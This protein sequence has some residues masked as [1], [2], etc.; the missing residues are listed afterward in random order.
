MKFLYSKI[1]F[2]FAIATCFGQQL[3]QIPDINFVHLTDLHV[4]VGNDNDFLLQKIIKEI[5]DSKNEF[6]VITGDLTNRGDDDELNRVHT[7]L[8]DLKIPYYVI[9]GNHET[10][11][12]ESAGLTYKKLWGEDRFV[13]SKGDY[14]FVGFPCGPYMKM[15]DGFVKK[16]DILLLDKTIEESLENSNKKVLSFSHYPL[17]NSLSNYKEVLSVLKKYPVVANF[18]GHGHTL[19]KYNFSGLSGLMG[20]SIISRDGKTR[21]YNE[22]VIN[23][24]SIS[25]YHKK[26][27]EKAV[28]THSVSTKPSTIVIEKESEL[29]QIKAFAN[30]IASIYSVPSFDKRNIYFANSLGTIQSVNLKNKKV[31]W[32]IETRNSIYFQPIIVKNNLIVGDIEGNIMAFDKQSSKQKWIRAVE[33]ILV[34]SPIVENEKLYVAS[35]RKFIC[36]DVNNGKVIWE[37]KLPQSYSQGIPLIHQNSIIFGAW[38]TFIYCL[39]KNTG[40]LLWKWNNGN[41]KQELYSAGN[42]GGVSSNNRLYFVT[43]QRFLTILDINTGKTLLRTSKW[44]VRE[45]MGKSQ[46][47]KFFYAKTMDGELL[48]LPLSDDLELTEENLVKESRILDLKIG[49]EHNPAAI[50]EN[51]GKIYLGSRKGEVVIVDA[52]KFEVI[53][54][55]NLG[56][57][58][59]NGFTTDDNGTVWTSLIE[60]G[61]YRLE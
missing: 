2:V 9:S 20:I 8:T 57:S 56:T 3:K 13:F 46:D 60:G 6:V 35:S 26:I 38:D 16:E 58:S 7:I 30:D 18:C 48:R 41:E 27:D 55:L 14:L 51:N 5:N 15:G 52:N 11:W 22:V 10:T 31:N 54:T 47:G 45:S 19:K 23:N 49:Y 1:L 50:L 17:D 39:D 25:V 32:Q 34:G 61:I 12:S 40:G 44:K 53:K 4:S 28:F 33:G 59:V 37:N 42:V 21:S 43:P 36:L 29:N 24:D